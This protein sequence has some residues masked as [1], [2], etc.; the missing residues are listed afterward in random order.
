MTSRNICLL[1]VL[2]LFLTFTFTGQSQVVPNQPNIKV[3]VDIKGSD[4][5]VTTLIRSHIK[6]ELRNLGDVDI[7]KSLDAWEYAIKI[8]YLKVKT[9][10]GME[11]G[12]L[13]MANG[14]FRREK[15]AMFAVAYYSA[16]LSP[17]YWHRENLPDYCVMSVDYLNEWH[18]EYSSKR[19][20]A[21]LYKRNL[22]TH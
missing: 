16:D 9:M 21:K 22:T 7:V 5:T 17:A 11:T 10:T 2:G 18:L 8:R 1:I 4:N 15:N 13:A 12:Y 14:Y 3:F 6:R 20:V 19:I